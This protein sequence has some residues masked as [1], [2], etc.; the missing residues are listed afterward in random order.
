MKLKRPISTWDEY[1]SAEPVSRETIG[2]LAVYERLLNE[3]SR[4]INLVS[5]ATLSEV[6]LRHF[7]DSLQLRK[8]TK[9][10]SVFLDLGSGAGFPGLVLALDAIG[11]DARF[12]LV[13]A[14]Q[15]KC[16]FLRAVVLET[17]AAVEIHCARIE[18]IIESLPKVD[19]IT[20][21]ALKPLPQ[22]IAMAALKFDEGSLGVFPKG[23][24]FAIELTSAEAQSNYILDSFQS[25]TQADS[26]IVT[27]KP[28]VWS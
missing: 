21:R 4:V 27:V 26:R 25:L 28:R 24:E 10:A 2:A 3:W 12:H 22:L 5:E 23:R 6:W 18:Q 7:A 15:R 8:F 17:G 11:T 19:V 9:G 14:D 16:A 1:C 13:E 20:A